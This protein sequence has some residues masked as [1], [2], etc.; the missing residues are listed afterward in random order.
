MAT[1]VLVHGFWADGS[2]WSGVITELLSA[3]HRPLAVQLPLSSLADDVATVDRVLARVPGPVI[4][5]G[6]SY[7]GVVVTAAG[8]T[9]KVAALVYVA[10]YAPERDENVNAINDRYPPSSMGRA[11]RATDDGHLWLDEALFAEVFAHDV[12]PQRTAVMAVAQGPASVNCLV[13]LAIEPAWKTKPSRW[14]LPTADATISPDA[15]R[16]MAERAGSTVTELT[17]SHAVLVARP[18]ETAA[19]IQQAA[20]PA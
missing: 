1:I 16:W 5:V 14:I 15:Q 3:G 18:G 10:A 17:S 8:N 2:S 19:V 11:I 7:G 6:H 4:L 13:E 9:E 20:G 12:D